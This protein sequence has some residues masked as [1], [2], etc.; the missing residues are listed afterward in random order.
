MYDTI[1]ALLE[2]C[3]KCTSE[4]PVGFR[5]TLDYVKANSINPSIIELMNIISDKDESYFATCTRT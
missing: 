1:E 2:D 5:N 3:E 4:Q